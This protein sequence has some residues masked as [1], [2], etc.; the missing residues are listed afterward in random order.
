MPIAP[1]EGLN[2]LFD[3]IAQRLNPQVAQ[4]HPAQKRERILQLLRENRVLILIDHPAIIEDAAFLPWAHDVVGDNEVSSK[5]VIVTRRKD[6]LIGS[7]TQVAGL[8][9][10]EGEQLIM[11]QAER[12]RAT[13]LVHASPSDKHEL[14]HATGGNPRAI[15]LVLD[16]LVETDDALPDAVDAL[17]QGHND[18]EAVFRELVIAEYNALSA[19]ERRTLHALMHFEAPAQRDALA[20]VMRVEPRR[21]HDLLKPLL[22]N[23]FVTREDGLFRLHPLVRAYTLAERA[24]SGDGAVDDRATR[25]RMA[26]HYKRHIGEHLE[27]LTVRQQT[28]QDHAMNGHVFEA[29]NAGAVM[30]WLVGVEQMEEFAWFLPRVRHLLYESAHGGGADRQHILDCCLHAVQWAKAHSGARAD[31]GAVASVLLE[32]FRLL[33]ED[34][35]EQPD[36]WM[37]DKLLRMSEPVVARAKGA[38]QALLQPALQLARGKLA[39]RRALFDAWGSHGDA[40]AALEKSLSEVKPLLE[41]AYAALATLETRHEDL[42]LLAWLA[43]GECHHRSTKQPSESLRQWHAAAS[44]MLVGDG[45]AHEAWRWSAERI[46]AAL[47][48]ATARGSS[49]SKRAE[50]CLALRAHVESVSCLSTRAQG[51][52]ALAYCAEQAGQHELAATARQEVERWKQRLALTGP[53]CLEDM[54]WLHEH[55]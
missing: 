1:G 16:Q 30:R 26:D 52:A 12:T 48:R 51:Y 42:T 55:R 38:H 45:T 50:A 3:H 49:V 36:L 40:L 2:T 33:G 21:V 8:A 41:G 15:K 13:N 44:E 5:V 37:A 19:E 6:Q 4:L 7:E 20:A 14:I 27:R 32:V 17:R 47:A 22:D 29:G 11:L 43:W 54:L 9:D 35:L 53:I 10:D 23:W 25:E 18:Y 46:E 31:A 39:Y 24:G 28:Q 34:P